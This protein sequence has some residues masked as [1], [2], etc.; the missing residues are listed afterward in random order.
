MVR[1]DKVRHFFFLLSVVVR[2]S[3]EL[4]IHFPFFVFVSVASAV[5]RETTSDVSQTGVKDKEATFSRCHAT[6]SCA[7]LA[8]RRPPT[9]QSE[10]ANSSRAG[11]S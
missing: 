1:M 2:D 5:S 4:R 3:Q 8:A 6:A 9:H 10:R 11:R 7:W